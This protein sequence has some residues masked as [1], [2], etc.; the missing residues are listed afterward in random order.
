MWSEKCKDK[1]KC[2]Q[3]YNRRKIP[4]KVCEHECV[5]ES[6]CVCVCE[7]EDVWVCVCIYPNPITISQSYSIWTLE[8][9][10]KI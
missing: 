8:N 6:V 3:W 1:V 5:C 7:C 9:T 10:W 4:G 2:A